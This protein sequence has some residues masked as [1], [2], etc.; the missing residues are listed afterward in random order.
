MPLISRTTRTLRAKSKQLILLA[1]SLLLVLAAIEIA[2]RIFLPQVFEPHP[3]GLYVPDPDVGYALTPGFRG[4]WTGAEFEVPVEVNASGLRGAELRPRRPGTVRV[5][6]LGDSFTFAW[7]C[8]DEDGW[9]AVLEEM[10]G[11]ANPDLDVQVL[12]A[13][14]PGYGTD[15]ALAFLRARGAPLDPDVVIVGFFAGNDFDDNLVLATESHEIRDGM[16]HATS[17]P[18]PA[19][20]RTLHGAKRRSHL[21]TFA[22]ER[23]G[24]AAM[25][26]GLL[27]TLERSSSE[28]F[29]DDDAERATELLV[30]I[31]R[32]AAALGASTLFVFVPSKLQV[33]GGREPLRAAEV[34]EEAARRAEAPWID[35]T[36]VLARETGATDVYF[37]AD[38]HW[39]P[40]GNRLVAGAIALGLAEHGLV[41][42][43]ER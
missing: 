25:R 43:A 28:F 22:S 20:V 8:R 7:G 18:R 9:P 38:G 37:V 36:R 39:A 3:P 34:V 21:L 12:N 42:P 29:S 15:E 11:S 4:T 31:E 13:G 5:L 26:L 16:L 23:A 27:S 6:C 35:L 33:L 41:P 17:D 32:A 14:V 2:M 30:E 1:I 19:W 10:L 24:Y 40:G